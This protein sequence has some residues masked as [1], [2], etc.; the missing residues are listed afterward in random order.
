MTAQDLAL[1]LVTVAAIV[2]VGLLFVAVLALLRA[3][4]SLRATL[5]VLEADLREAGA[6]LAQTDADADRVGALL[7]DAEGLTAQLDSSTRLVQT[8][9]RNPVV[10]VLALLRGTGR[11]ARSVGS[12]RR[13]RARRAER[14][15]R[16]SAAKLEARRTRR[17]SD[18]EGSRS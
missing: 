14:R 1:V 3:L 13:R 12:R 18:V 9:V 7:S 4:R 17:S 6:L 16:R 8:A 11:T 15:R 2:G 5:G 10:K